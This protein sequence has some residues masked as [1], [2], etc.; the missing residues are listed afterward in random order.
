MERRNFLA[1]LGKCGLSVGLLSI[2]PSVLAGE[3]KTAGVIR[4]EDD[5]NVIKHS[6]TEKMEFAEEWVKKFMG[7]LDENLDE[8]TRNKVM[9]CNGK[10]CFS[11]YLKKEGHVINPV[12]FD[13]FVKWAENVTDGSIRIEGNTIYFAY[14]SNYQGKPAPEEMCLCPFVESKPSGLSPT[15]CQCSVGYVREYFSRILGRPVKVELQES[16]LRGGKRC[17]FKIDV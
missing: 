13:R 3:E 14:M 15:Y 12:S 11:S 16:V 7:V 5:P 6:C 9:E 2:M 8:P 17:R 4:P 10:V 1:S